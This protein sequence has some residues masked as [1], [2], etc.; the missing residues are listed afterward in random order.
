MATKHLA[1]LRGKIAQLNAMAGTLEHL[2]RHCHGD[3][4]PECPILEDLAQ[5]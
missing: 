1:A 5:D 3:Q 4:R 2:T